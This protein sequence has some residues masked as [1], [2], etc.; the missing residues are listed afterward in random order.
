MRLAK[1]F[2]VMSTVSL[3]LLDRSF[4]QEEKKDEKPAVAEKEKTSKDALELS[5][6]KGARL[7]FESTLVPVE[8]RREREKTQEKGHEGGKNTYR[9]MVQ[10]VEANGDVTLMITMDA[11]KDQDGEKAGAAKGDPGKT[12]KGDGESTIAVVLGPD[13]RVKRELSKTSIPDELCSQF[14]IIFASGLQRKSLKAGKDYPLS[15][16]YRRQALDKAGDEIQLRFA[17]IQHDGGN[18]LARFAILASAESRP[19]PASGR[20]EKGTEKEPGKEPGDPKRN[21]A[22]DKDEAGESTA[23]NASKDDPR[24]LGE[25]TYRMED[26]VLEKV[27]FTGEVHPLKLARGLS[28]KRVNSSR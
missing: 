2:A 21:T 13:G 25:A 7:A 17:G 1:I 10:E 5:L 9:V 16:F 15:P 28:I 12:S 11:G 24:I 27:T 22:K 6:K 20:S 14:Q 4:A 3:L 8:R 18:Q 26:G 23:S 19:L